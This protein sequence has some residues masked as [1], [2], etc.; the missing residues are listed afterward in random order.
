MKVLF[1]PSWYPTKI[2]Q[3]T[4]IFILRHAKAI[5]LKHQVNVAFAKRNDAQ[6]EV[7]ATEQNKEGN[8]HQHIC[9]YKGS[10]IPVFGPFLNFYRY[11]RAWN[12]AIYTALVTHHPDMIHINVVWPV[13]L[14]YLVTKKLHRLPMHITEHWSGY[15]EA[16]GAFKQQLINRWISRKVFRKAFS[17]SVVSKPN[18][19][20]IIKHG[21][22]QKV[23][24]ITNVVDSIF[25]FEEIEKPKKLTFLHVSSLVE[26]EKN[27]RAMLFAFELFSR[28]NK[29]KAK[30]IIVGG[31]NRFDDYR[32]EIKRMIALDIEIEYRGN[33]PAT[34]VAKLMHLSHALLLPSHFEGQPVVVLEALSCGLPVIA[35]ATG[36]IPDC[37]NDENGILMEKN[38]TM[39]I[40]ESMNT[41]YSR[42]KDFDRK[43]IAQEA[44]K[45][46]APERIAM[47]FDS[48]YQEM[49]QNPKWKA[50]L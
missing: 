22:H 32:D 48:I 36:A 42:F 11:L 21:L 33:L 35:S 45:L 26:R 9:F 3:I 7:F 37:V 39:H 31:E 6:N 13:G 17:V 49:Y 41:F 2:D 19:E 10:N 14:I 27:I 5:A 38:D 47:Q 24:L 29:T 12:K 18:L 25:R 50:A 40:F 44:H 1:L 23:L 46:Y 43:K 16:D 30:L 34:E 4:G 15:L 20:A 28:K 8:L